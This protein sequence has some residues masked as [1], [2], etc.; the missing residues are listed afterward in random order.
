MNILYYYFPLVADENRNAKHNLTISL[1]DFPLVDD[2]NRN[3]KRNLTT[4]Y[5]RLGT[6]GGRPQRTLSFRYTKCDIQDSQFIFGNCIIKPNLDCNYTF[7]ID[8]APKGIPIG[9]KS[10]GNV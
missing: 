4:L 9:A 7:P 1:L 2:E 5:K 10:I 3:K 6:C 8:L